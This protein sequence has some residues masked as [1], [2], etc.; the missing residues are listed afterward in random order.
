M[1]INHLFGV[2]A[3]RVQM[4]GHQIESSTQL[5]QMKWSS[6]FFEK[7]KKKKPEQRLQSDI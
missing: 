6:P 4:F 5:H 3:I 2:A 7:K 1:G